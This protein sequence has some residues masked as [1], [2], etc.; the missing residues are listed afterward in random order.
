MRVVVT[1]GAGFIGSRVVDVLVAQGADVTV[2]DV[3]AT[4]REDCRTVDGSVLDGELLRKQLQGAD[5]V[6]HLAGFVREGIRKQPYVGTTLQ[7][8]GTLNVLDACCANDV[9]HLAYASSFYVYDGIPSDEKVDE[10]TRLDPLIMELFGSAKYMG[11]TLCLE[12]ARDGGPACGIFRI[13]PVY[14]PGGSSAVGE[15]IETGL[16]GETIEVWGS[17]HRRNQYT[18]VDDVAEGIVAGLRT[19][20]IFNL[21]SPEIVSIRELAG[22][23]SEDYGFRATFDESR[24][25]GPSFPYI[26]EEKAERVLGWQSTCLRDG[27]KRTVD[28]TAELERLRHA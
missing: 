6:V 12:W 5:A 3:Q 8:Q 22:L 10:T 28:G 4:K 13:G 15:F 16:R 2:L 24:P 9:A 25:E 27:V 26:S 21:I 18:Y 11:E 20:E 1:G 17:G 23:L 14:G 19:P 7:L